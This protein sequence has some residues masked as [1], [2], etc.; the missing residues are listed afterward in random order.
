[1]NLFINHLE[2]FRSPIGQNFPIAPPVARLGAIDDEQ[3]LEGVHDRPEPDPST[4]RGWTPQWRRRSSR[5]RRSPAARS[6]P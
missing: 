2:Y 3:A 5:T 6:S 1:M 4:V